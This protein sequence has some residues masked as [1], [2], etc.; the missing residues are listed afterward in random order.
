MRTPASLL[1]ATCLALGASGLQ[2]AATIT[3]VNADPANVGF[4][5]PTVVAGL[6]GD[7]LEGAFRGSFATVTFAVLDEWRDR[8]NIGA[9][10][11]RFA[12][13]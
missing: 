10:E 11:R 12:C 6:F 1:L 5:D 8:R 2:A 4:N 13:G 9:F 7:A 3:I